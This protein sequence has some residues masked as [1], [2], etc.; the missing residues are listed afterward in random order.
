MDTLDVL[1]H[2]YRP[3]LLD[4]PLRDA[5]DIA[6]AVVIE[7]S[8]A[9][10]KTMTALKAANSY[11]LVDDD[12]RALIA[13]SP[14]AVLDGERP[15]L[16]DEWQVEPT[17]WNRVR[18]AVDRSS[19]PGQFILTGSALPADDITRHTGA[20]RFLHLRQRTMGW[21]EKLPPV[22]H[23]VSVRALFDGHLPSPSTASMGLDDLID[24]LLRP[25]FPAMTDLGTPASAR[26][27]RAYIDDVARADVPRLA[28]IRH[29]PAVIRQ[30]ILSLARSSGSE[31]TYRTLATDVA[32]V[33]S[34]I[35]PE[36]VSDYVELLERLFVVERQPAWTPRLQ[37]RARVRTAA[38]IHLVDPALAAAAL[39]AGSTHLKKDLSLLGLLF[40]SA[41]VHDLA[42]FADGLGGEIRHF[43]DSNGREI[44]A[45]IT[46]PD[47]RWAAVEIKLGGAQAAD[48]SASLNAAVSTLDPSA[49]GE[50]AFK[51]VVTGTGPTVVTDDGVVVTS[52][53]A[54]APCPSLRQCAT[55]RP[56]THTPPG[57]SSTARSH[58]AAAIRADR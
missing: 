52:L 23:Q 35:R 9:A 51:L 16:L 46:L 45:I 42:C 54:L 20:G 1:G 30:L 29:D 38:K 26:R 14:A 12:T 5:L 40:E 6:G 39:G 44:D 47:G 31:A 33:A 28:R 13:L 8:R 53:R 48:G 55:A 36:T 3:R 19:G 32:V 11:A 34:G 56:P 49:S 2:D 7:G 15:R 4:A 22:R 27:L 58:P 18:R 37:S 10:G 50:P 25:G 21:F 57:G 24:A 17:L 43:L 41:V